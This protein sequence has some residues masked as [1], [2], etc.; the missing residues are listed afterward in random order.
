MNTIH[1]DIFKAIHEGKWLT[2]E[3]RNQQEQVTRYW[4]GIRDL[5]AARRTLTVDGLHLGKYSLQQYDRIY[6]DSILSSQVLEGSYCEINQAL[7]QDIHE[8]SYKYKPLFDH[9]ANLKVLDYLED[10]SRM[11]TTAYRKDFALVRYLDR[12]SFHGEAYPLS[13]EQFQRIVQ[14]FQRQA[15]K[16]R[17]GAGEEPL[18]S[19][20]ETAAKLCTPKKRLSI[21]RLAMNVMSIHT[22][23]GLYVLA[24]RKLNLDVR[25]RCLRPDEDI[26]LCTE[27]TVNGNRE[28][29]RRY[30][31]AEDY[32]LLQDFEANQEKVKDAVTRY[33]CRVQ[34]VDDLPYVIGLGMDLVLDLHREYNA[35]LEMYQKGEVPAPIRAFF[36]DLLDRPRSRRMVPITPVAR[37]IKLDPVLAIMHGK[38]V[39][40]PG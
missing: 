7:V 37:G 19:G 36:G 12:E 26:T 13:E 2:I 15:E 21:Q 8:N 1:R 25:Q 17:H 4:I 33:S 29:I 35:I 32:E 28:S 23:R 16:E 24:Y 31:D 39:R 10:C 20:T 22:P 14:E 6:I 27:F 34:G 9:V 30:L 11:D 40:A 5:N 3:Y 38:S 18:P